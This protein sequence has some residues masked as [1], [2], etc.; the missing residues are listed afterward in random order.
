LQ[1]RVEGHRLIQV[2]Y[3][4]DPYK[5]KVHVEEETQDEKEWKA[6]VHEQRERRNDPTYDPVTYM[7]GTSTLDAMTASV[8]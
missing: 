1:I 2:R 7:D 8:G 6:Y 4:G 5:A 3:Q